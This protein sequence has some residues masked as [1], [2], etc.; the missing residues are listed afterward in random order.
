MGY[1]FR[2]GIQSLLLN[3]G[4]KKFFDTEFVLGIEPRKRGPLIEYLKL[5]CSGADS[6]TEMCYHRTE[7]LRI[8]ASTSSRSSAAF[9]LDNDGDLDVVVNNMNDRPQVFLSNLSAQQ[10]IH[11]LKIRLKG[12]KSNADGL[13][14]VVRVHAGGRIWT[15]QHDGKSGYLS[16][17]S[18]PLYFG[19]G[20]AI[21][22]DWVE[23]LWPLGRTQRRTTD[24]PI[25][26]VVRITEEPAQ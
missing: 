12:T 10:K 21:A 17:S 15:Q 25:N 22:V 6:K 16:Q 19:L 7:D 2:Y 8:I 5:E 18:M 3:D 26:T 24:L 4:G 11:F 23:I 14:S 20:D 9:D 13:G 1:P